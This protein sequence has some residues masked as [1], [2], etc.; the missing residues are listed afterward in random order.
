MILYSLRS[1]PLLRSRTLA[2]RT[3]RSISKRARMSLETASQERTAELLESLAEIQ[4]RTKAASS[5]S[6]STLIAVS[7]L[8]PASDILLCHGAGQLD[9]GEN[10]V[11]ELE[12]KAQILPTDIR[13]HFIGTLQSNK[14][15]ALAS[16]IPNLFCVQTLGSV[17]A[18]AALN[19]ALPEERTLRVL[20]QVNTSGEDSKSGLPALTASSDLVSSELAQLA[21]HVLLE[22]PKLRLAGLMTIGALEQSL[23]ASET[24]KNADFET[25]KATRD[26][27]AGYL[28]SSFPEKKDSWGEDGKLVLSMGMSSDFE[29]A[30][31][32]GSDIVRV[33]TGI[34]GSRPKKTTSQ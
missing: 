23:T 28:T 7:K 29:A 3:Y 13:W 14:A 10:Y 33:G 17:K 5:G 15:K 26:A 25:L 20:I 22:C 8:K 34:F 9:F 30:L 32:A 19:N 21:K 24:E 4:N 27:L 31:K 6:L 11:Q 12:E 16:A 18:A 1:S 2:P